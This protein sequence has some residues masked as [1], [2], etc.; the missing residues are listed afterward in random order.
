MRIIGGRLKGRRFSPP[1]DLKLRPTTDKAREALCN[2]LNHRI[3]IS[4]MR[5]LD[6]CCGSGAMSYEMISRGAGFVTAVD[7]NPG[8]V[9]FVAAQA[10]RFGI[11]DSIQVVCADAFEFLKGIKATPGFDF[12]FTDPPYALAGKEELIRLIFEKELLFEGG[13]LVFEHGQGYDLSS[14]EP[15]YIETRRYSN[16]CFS[17]FSPTAPINSF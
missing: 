9:R 11:A 6:L 13:L 14:F 1:A 2:M 5:M 4:E 17:F 8:V 16:V 15:Y 7:K 12:I 10:A 3:V